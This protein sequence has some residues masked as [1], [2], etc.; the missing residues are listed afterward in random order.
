M[1]GTVQKI[2]TLGDNSIKLAVYLEPGMTL[3]Q[4]GHLSFQEIE[5]G[6]ASDLPT[7][8][9]DESLQRL[10]EQGDRLIAAHS[11]LVG[12]V[13]AELGINDDTEDMSCYNS[14]CDYHTDGVCSDRDNVMTCDVRV[15]KDDTSR[16]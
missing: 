14:A 4:V 16:D 11:E 13:K 1:K 6:L 5:F 15:R 7:V 10:V 3:A 2:E 9:R 12:M 8:E